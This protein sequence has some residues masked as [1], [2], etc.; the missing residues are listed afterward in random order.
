MKI[1]RQLVVP[2]VFQVLLSSIASCNNPTRGSMSNL[3]S[4]INISFAIASNYNTDKNILAREEYIGRLPFGWSPLHVASLVGATPAL[5]SLI[6]LGYD[7]NATDS[8]GETVVGVAKSPEA[9][10]SLVEAG[11]ELNRH[12]D[13]V[14]PPLISS[15]KRMN[16]DTTEA[17][18]EAGAD[19][20]LH[21]YSKVPDFIAI[22]GE[23]TLKSLLPIHYAILMR[24]PA[25]IKLLFLHGAKKDI[26]E[27]KP[28]IHLAAMLDDR[29]IMKVLLEEGCSPN[30]ANFH[31]RTAAHYILDKGKDSDLVRLLLDYG[32]DVNSP[33]EDGVL[34]IAFAR[35]EQ[36]VRMLLEAGSDVRA[37]DKRGATI[38]VYAIAVGAED[39]AIDAII[40]AGVDL[41]AQTDDGVTALS[42]ARD[43]DRIQVVEMI[44]A[45]LSRGRIEEK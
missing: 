43:N 26:P 22:N 34:P 12:K 1:A 44:E 33:D 6:S 2:A 28:P 30:Q 11:A 29:R 23:K 31:G 15:I 41:G 35:K 38:L 45:E 21:E 4:L 24:D 13:D 8:S 36:D 5:R 18:L 20:N 37:L 3:P 32:L 10:R 25:T 40:K 7:V 14:I 17:L 39:S 9:A 42:I 19:P 27:L 16:Y